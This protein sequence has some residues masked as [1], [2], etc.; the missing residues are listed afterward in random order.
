MTLVSEVDVGLRRV[1]T[2]SIT[3]SIGELSSYYKERDLNISPEFQRAFR[4]PSDKKS[5]LI[6]SVLLAIPIPSV[7]VFEN[8]DGSWELVDG[9]QRLSTIFEF[10][11]IL[12]DSE[13]DAVRPPSVLNS[14]RYLPSL[15]NVVWEKSDLINDVPKKQQTPLDG[16]LQRKIR[17]ARIQVEILRHPSDVETKYDL[18]QRLNRGGETA[19]AQEV[20]NSLCV[21][22]SAKGFAEIKKFANSE[23]FQN[24]FKVTSTGIEQQRHIEYVMRLIVHTYFDFDTAKDL[25]AFVDDGMRA[26]L[27]NP[28]DYEWKKRVSL[29]LTQLT[30]ACGDVALLPR[31]GVS[32][33]ANRVTLRQ[34]EAI[35]VGVARNAEAISELK[36]PKKFL[37]KK[38][39]DFWD[40][41]EVAH[42]SAAGLNSSVRLQRTVP[43]GE[44][45]FKPGDD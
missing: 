7:F 45:W 12:R 11:G 21:M 35:A 16:A 26:I 5:N 14:T 3:M 39:T 6:E 32:K 23:L 8:S 13:T 27:T 20:R 43:F 37:K 33:N 18:F 17:T 40:R 25:E 19:N 22:A 10:M 31:L 15:R 36:A 44:S 34:L 2:D 30:N 42:M 29:A 9:L 41:D 24:L 38:I 4:W 28:K 1:A